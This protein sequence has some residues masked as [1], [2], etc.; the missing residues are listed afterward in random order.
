VSTPRRSGAQ[1]DFR[2]TSV[3]QLEELAKANEALVEKARAMA[4]GTYTPNGATETK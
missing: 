1:Q 4:S 2:A 3:E